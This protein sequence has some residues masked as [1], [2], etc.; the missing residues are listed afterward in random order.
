MTTFKYADSLIEICVEPRSKAEHPALLSVL[1]GLVAEHT[2]L[3]VEIDPDSNQ[4]LLRGQS[5]RQLEKAIRQLKT[6]GIE[7]RTGRPQIRYL[8]ALMRPATTEDTHHLSASVPKDVARVGLR[9]EPLFPSI[10]NDYV[11]AIAHD[12]ASV[13]H[14]ATV[15]RTIRSFWRE[16]PLIGMRMIGTKATLLAI[17][18]DD[19]HTSEVTVA[20]ATRFAFKEACRNGSIRIFEPIM[21]VGVLTPEDFIGSVILDLNSRR[22]MILDQSAEGEMVRMRSHA[23]LG[24]LFGYESTLRSLTNSR[25]SFTIEYSHHDVIPHNV[26][27]GDPDNLP[28]AIGMRA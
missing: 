4:I 20:S 7:V 22:A 26:A 17:D 6:R 24:N 9:L 27:P 15:E 2:G 23:P 18:C 1:D 8:E 11:S 25:A 3:A 16:G 21:S 19:I 28:P 10:E 5:E 14:L 12:S 13:A